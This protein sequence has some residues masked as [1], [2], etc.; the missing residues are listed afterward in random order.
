LNPLEVRAF[1]RQDQLILDARSPAE[2]ELGHLPGAR[3]LPIFD[4]E[5]RAEIG[6]LYKQKGRD[7]AVLRGLEIVGPKMAPWVSQVKNWLKESGYQQLGIY[8]WRGGMRSG[9]MAWLFSQAGV[10]VN[11]LIGGYKSY[12]QILL[13]DLSSIPRL[14]ILGGPTGSGKTEVLK[15]LSEFGEQVIDL[16]ALANHRGSAFGALGQDKQPSN[17][18]FQ[19]ELFD[20]FQALNIENRIW[21]ESESKNIGKCYLPDSFWELMN[22]RPVL[23]MDVS[24][25]QRVPR[26]VEEYGQFGTDR[27]QESVSKLQRKLGL[28]RVRKLN[29]ALDE[30]RLDVVAED[31]LRYYDQAYA[32]SFEK[33][34]RGNPEVLSCKSANPEEN[35]KLVLQ[36]VEELAW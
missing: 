4:D 31:L 32:Y 15:Y 21:V 6:T 23:K 34:K 13:D 35:A 30:N 27:L 18:Q 33:Y 24:I 14:C 22:T 36:K 7:Q 11:Q 10:S 25:E 16:E 20:C 8:C 1:L 29:D 2:F 19:N 5:Q 12:R 28:E 17:Q 3:S 9:S 26:L